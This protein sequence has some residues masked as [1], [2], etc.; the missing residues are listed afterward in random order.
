MNKHFD[1]VIFDL[2]GVITQTALVHSAAWKKMFDDFLQFYAKKQGSE[3]NEFTHKD[4]YLPFVDGKPRYKGVA[5]FLASRGIELPE[6]TPDDAPGFDT[7][8]ALGNKKNDAFNEVL[9]QNGV[10]VYPSTVSLMKELRRKGYRVGVASSSKNCEQVLKTAGLLHLVETR[11]DGVVSAEIGLKGKPE[12]DIFTTAADNLGCTYDRCI[13]VEDAVSGVQAGRNGRFG[14][15]LG[16]AREENAR[17]LLINGADIVLEDMAETSIGKMNEWFETGLEADQWSISYHDY[18]L[19]KE[20]SRETLLTVGN[21]YFGTR[22]AMEEMDA[23]AVN[24]PGTYMAGM[25]NRL[26]TKIADR[27]IENEDFV[28]CINWLPLTFRIDGGD[29][30]DANNTKLLG[31]K[32]KLNLKNGL[33]C[34]EMRFEDAEGRQTQIVSERFASMDNPQLAAMRYLITPLNYSGTIEIKSG[35]DGKLTNQGV[36]RYKALSS[37]HLD[38]IDEGVENEKLYVLVKTNQSGYQIAAAAKH[39]LLQN[40]IAVD[41]K[42]EISITSGQVFANYKMETK[43]NETVTIDKIVS[44]GSDKEFFIE[45]ALLSVQSLLD[46]PKQFDELLAE[47]TAVW[48][49]LWD[50]M[51]VK[52]TGDRLSQKLLRLHLFHLMVSVSP[53]NNLLDASI[54]ARGLHGEAYRGHIFWDELY[55][56]P[57]YDLH[58]PEA[59]RSMLMYRYRRLEEAR[60][61]AKQHGYQGAMFPWQSG[62][63]GR[64]E[65]QV[66]HLNPLTGKWGD[67]YSSLQR[68]VSLAIAYNVWDYYWISEDLDFL[69]EYG[70]E[71]FFDIAR[72]W[73]SKATLN[74]QTGRYEIIGV[75]GPDEFH[76]HMSG[77]EEGGLKDNTYTNLMVAW[78][79][80][81]TANIKTIIGEDFEQVAGKMQL[82]A[83][84]LDI[85]GHIARNLNIVFNQEGI[86]AQYDGYFGLKEL[87]W[88]YYRQKYGNVYR[89]DRILKAEGKSA[90]E[91]KVA[92]QADTLM[93]FYNLNKDEVDKLLFDMGYEL[94]MDYL[95]RNLHYYLQRTSHGSTLSRLVHAR[96]AAMTG[97]RQLS[98]DLYQDA[99][100]SDYIDI[101][102]GTTGEGIHAGVMAGTILITLNT[103]AGINYREKE[104]HIEPNLP[105]NWR[106][107]S[108]KLNFKGVH[109]SFCL[110]KSGLEVMADAH[111]TIYVYGKMLTLE[112]GKTKDISF[113]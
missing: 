4:D 45:N 32:R 36:E 57:L 87:D 46:D 42:A 11:V 40:G 31:I 5:D 54:T 6:G 8:C 55:I 44:L 60:K 72:F 3:F 102:G 70:A 66:V 50:D 35:L 85:W 48:K 65:T 81:K 62:S 19:K 20:R 28:N 68:H 105:E 100:Q 108:F 12:A 69:K 13:V 75:M 16:L 30:F 10:T 91:Y 37:N 96:L 74:Q 64:E 83:D 107:L 110:S 51:D 101:Q 104:L 34:R 73:A 106:E 92:K 53:V 77:S 56:L 82:S 113:G 58:L 26:I 33:L 14:L 47:S 9:A 78:L 43:Q 84:E 95:Q 1:A 23:N 67:D 97:N 109:Y 63:D 80:N 112:A 98:W 88:D 41:C 94:P 61:Y 99:L 21:G 49:Q 38:Q 15:V 25:Y 2:D 7:V 93:A 111:A 24:Y 71:M 18:D 79:F 76:E 22:G 52:V 59:A 39:T 17:E 89:M 90:D 29:W 27:D 103:F 86:L